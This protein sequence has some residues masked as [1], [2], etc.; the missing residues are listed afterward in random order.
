MTAPRDRR[1]ERTIAAINR[2]LFEL[3]AERGYDKT[4]VQNIIDR[5]DVGRSTFYAHF[6][7]KDDLLLSSLDR[8]TADLD[9]HLPEPEPGGP[10]LPSLGLFVHV[11]SH[12]HIF[13][14]LFRSRAIDLVT[15]ETTAM[16]EARA[17][18]TLQA[19]AGEGGESHPVDA[20]VR[21]AFAA[22]ALMSFVRW[23]LAQGRPHG[24]EW[25]A[26]TFERLAASA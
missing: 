3:I 2:A 1:V 21:A 18:R 23:W 24:P 9:A 13:D 15:R 12:H 6:D 19:R 25:A 8:L 5:A 14:G 10:L 26:R 20:E 22:R 4:T 17:L 7:T 11:D 16:L